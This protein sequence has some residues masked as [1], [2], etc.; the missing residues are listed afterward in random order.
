MNN[1]EKAKALFDGLYNCSQS[2]F[3]AYSEKFGI[4][5]EDALK[6]SAGFGGG[7]A[8]TQ[9]LCGALAGAI[10]VLGCR[11]YDVNDSANSKEKVISKSNELLDRFKSINKT[12][13]CIELTG[14][15]F[16]MDTDR[17]LFKELRIQEVVCSK[18]IVDACKIL[19][20]L[21]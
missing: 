2:V 14:I 8:R 5:E 3:A 18:C 16:S 13:R 11:Y 4:K 20:E 10:M 19:E 17:K 15:D 7:I 1:T 6:V 21:L 9:E 12:T